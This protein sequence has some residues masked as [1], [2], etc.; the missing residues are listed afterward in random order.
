MG[1]D[2][3]YGT[4]VGLFQAVIGLALIIVANKATQKI[5]Q[6]SLW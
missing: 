4:A 5:G 6:T 1:A 2:Y 3:S